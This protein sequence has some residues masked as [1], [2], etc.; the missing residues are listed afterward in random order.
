M[1][2]LIAM[3][4]L[5]AAASVTA[6]CTSAA[7]PASAPTSNSTS[8]QAAKAAAAVCAQLQTAVSRDIGPIGTAF[9]TIVGDATAK[10]PAGVEEAETAATTALGKLG[11]DLESSVAAGTDP[12]VRAAVTT[13]RQNLTALTSD[14]SFL[15]DI[16]TMDGIAA[17]TTKLQT[18]TAPITTA[19]QG[20]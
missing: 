10:N 14:P 7:A 16:T 9:G 12:A 5:L 13:A 17:A 6:G 2:R 8:Q 18:A 15:S 19:C 11:S 3:S 20:S 1:R 4:M